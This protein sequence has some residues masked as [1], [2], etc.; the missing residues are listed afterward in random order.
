MTWMGES[1]GVY[2]VNQAEDAAGDTLVLAMD[3]GSNEECVYYA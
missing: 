1:V 2:S 3:P